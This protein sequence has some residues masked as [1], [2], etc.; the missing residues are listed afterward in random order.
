MTLREAF[1]LAVMTALVT[2]GMIYFHRGLC[3][4]LN[5]CGLQ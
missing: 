1:C 2:V 3:A 5:A 4:P